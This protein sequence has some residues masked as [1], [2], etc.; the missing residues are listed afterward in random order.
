MFNS[1][2]FLK[3]KSCVYVFPLFMEIM[4]SG[5]PTK[6]IKSAPLSRN[7][8]EGDFSSVSI[9]IEIKTK[10]QQLQSQSGTYVSKI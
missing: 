4:G 8:G 6:W 2:Q 5:N 3:E 7:G 9:A 10:T 1:S